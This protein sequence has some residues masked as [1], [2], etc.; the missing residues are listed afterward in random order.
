[1]SSSQCP[2]YLV[3]GSGIAALTFSALMARAGKNVHV[4]ESHYLPGGY[5][6]TFEAGDYRFNA[7]LHYVWNC[8]KG[9]TV[10]RMLDKLGL[11]ETVTFEQYNPDGFDHMRM[12]G[13]SLDV[14]GD[15]KLLEE[16]LAALFPQS[17][18][19]IGE[20]IA[21]VWATAEELDRFP[22][23]ASTLALLPRA[24]RFRRVMKYR[25]A[26]LQQVFDRYGLPLPAQTLL[27]LQWPDFLLPPE[28]LSFF[29]WVMLF[30][31]YCRGAYYPTHHFEHVIDSLV[32]IITSHGGEVSLGHKVIE[33][34]FEGERVVG[35]RS[36][37]VGRHGERLG[38]GDTHDGD[39]VI[40]NMDPRRA[41]EMMGLWRFSKQL[42]RKLD[43][44]Y[45]PSNFMVYL[46][47]RDLDLREYGFGRFNLFHTDE[48]DLNKAFHS[49]D[50]KGDY[51]KPSF[52]VTTPSL[53]TDD[54]SDRPPNT[55]LLELLTV[56]DF[57]RFRDLK[58]AN[59]HAYT[60]K[61]DEIFESMMRVLER[62]YVPGL[63]DHVCFKML[64]SPT[65]NVRYCSSAMGNSYG[66]DMT[67]ANIT[68]GRLNHE[69]SIPGLFFC[70]ASSGFAG[71]A[72]TVWT[73]SRLYETLTGDRFLESR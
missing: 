39:H 3:V 63:R 42:R 40:C 16:R 41:A 13:Y 9:R 18:A 8:G 62:D 38:G 56:A 72:G 58:F 25:S 64:G 7:Q 57:A 20:F 43:Y 28:R 69:T 1:M 51:S 53:L 73:G 71:F 35:V 45:S 47:V 10:H 6:H 37:R 11:A 68:A 32:E 15:P 44:D 48:P 27:A 22:S 34:L 31:G 30:V 54:E 17:R 5:G 29:A 61:K 4:I 52:A 23:D 21:E 19:N 59:S 67:P 70:N 12:P 55:Q 33:F 49:M 66:S 14:P 24:H 65:T 26:T 46:A 2:D 36:E 60:K 50:R